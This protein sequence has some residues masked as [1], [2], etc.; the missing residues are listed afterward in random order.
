MKHPLECYS[1]YL[2]GRRLTDAEVAALRAW[3]LEDPRNLTEFVEF[4]V[5]HTSITDRL[6]LARLLEDMAAH[7]LGRA[8]R[9]D[10]VAD[11]ICE[12]ES[13]SPRAI[14]PA[15]A[16]VPEIVAPSRW[17]SLVPA[18]A[19]AAVLL[20]AFGLLAMNSA[21]VGSPD[22]SSQLAGTNTTPVPVPPKEVAQVEAS[23]DAKWADNA[24]V[25]LGHVFHEGDRLNLLSG[26]VELQMESGTTV[27]IEGP[28]DCDLLTADSL[29]L[30]HGK[31]AV[32]I[33]EGANSFVVDLPTMQ[34]IDLG[35]EFG[36]G[37]STTGENLVSVFEGSVA[38]AGPDEEPEAASDPRTAAGARRIESGLEVS[39]P[40]GSPLETLPWAPQEIANDRAFVRPDEVAIRARAA[41]GSLPDQ[42]LA[43]HYARRR[44][45]G[46]LAY[47]G[48]DVP[49][50]ASE[51]T[52]GLAPAP[53]AGDGAMALVDAAAGAVG[54]VDVWGGAVFL[55][56]DLSA[57]GP[58]ARAGLLSPSGRIRRAGSEVWVMWRTRRVANA[59]PDQQGSAG[60]SLMFGDRNDFDEPLFVGRPFG[61]GSTLG[62]ESAWG[63]APP[64][65]GRRDTVVLDA[66]PEPGLQSAEIDDDEHVWLARIEFRN[67]ADRVS[68]WLDPD[69]SKLDAGSPDGALDVSAV[70]FDRVRLAVNRGNESWRFS[71]FAMALHP[72]ALVELQRTTRRP[73]LPTAELIGQTSQ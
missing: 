66:A 27:V 44:I 33:G 38:I 46:L 71:E 49:S 24:R 39:V 57:E 59:E 32:R 13:N 35:T 14:V 18:A 2:D 40:S 42:K 72:E 9:P 70:E 50:L 43:A 62:V 31:S 20:V 7:R 22:I 12:I 21:I 53:L 65:E 51:F 56:L 52:L 73:E 54:G 61:P 28:S 60:L 34:V 17:K 45:E 16:A 30:N 37:A 10:L 5:V 64:P 48:F 3:I 11:A 58:F 68:V 1:A 55:Q 15:S 41:E 6:R 36:V 19:V 8:I 25:E 67:L 69:L 26:V 63:G 4:A 29:R 23:F 47:Q